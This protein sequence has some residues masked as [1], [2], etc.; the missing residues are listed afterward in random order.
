MM[1][2]S[3]TLVYDGD[4]AFC[5]RCVE[6]MKRRMRHLPVIVP[7]QRADLETL[8]LSAAQCQAALQFVDTNGRIRSGE[9][10][11]AQVLLQAGRGWRVLGVLLLV[12]G[13][14]HL[15]GLV[16]RW[17]ARNRHRLP[18]GTASCGISV[19]GSPPEMENSTE[20]G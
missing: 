4:C 6:W 8:G 17:V 16:Y 3:P 15:A 14:R 12:P 19:A 7:W 13:V 11:V 2:H 1:N 20:R 18:G 10:A 5:T 9:R